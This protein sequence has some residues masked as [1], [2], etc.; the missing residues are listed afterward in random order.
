MAKKEEEKKEPLFKGFCD[1]KNCPYYLEE[2]SISF[3]DPSG[4]MIVELCSFLNR[5]SFG[6]LSS[7]PKANYRFN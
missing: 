7:C 6:C 4:K 3:S 1:R 5:R 2:E